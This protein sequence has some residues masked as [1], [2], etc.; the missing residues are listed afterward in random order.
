[1]IK[2]VPTLDAVQRAALT[3]YST[4]LLRDF[5][6]TTAGVQSATITTYDGVTVASTLQGKHEGDKLS[7]M[8]SSISA[9]AAALTRE[10]GHSEPDRVLLESKNGRIVSLKV[11][12]TRLGLVFTVVTDH[13]A[14]LGTLL[15][16]CRATTEKLAGHVA[17]QT[18]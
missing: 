4:E 16:N 5:C 6:A 7:A 10:V 3:V 1:M 12:T 17:R 13:N 11:P 8:A 18:N 9:L 14:V 2:T 15:W